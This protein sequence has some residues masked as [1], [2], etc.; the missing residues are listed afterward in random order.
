MSF[1][2]AGHKAM[3]REKSSVVPIGHFLCMAWH[4]GEGSG[5]RCCYHPSRVKRCKPSPPANAYIEAKVNAKIGLTVARYHVMMMAI[6]R[7]ITR[8]IV[9]MHIGST[10]VQLLW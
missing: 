8:G 5:V 10:P 2:L 1:T 4:V 7:E 9:S 3:R 6:I